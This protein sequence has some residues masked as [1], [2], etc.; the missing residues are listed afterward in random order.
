MADEKVQFNFSKTHIKIFK[1]FRYEISPKGVFFYKKHIPQLRQK[2]N[3]SHGMTNSFGAFYR[4]ISIVIKTQL[5]NKNGRILNLEVTIDDTEY[6]LAN[7][8][9]E[10]TEQDQLETIQNLFI[11]LENFGN[12]YNKSVINARDFN[13]LFSKILRYKGRKP[14]P[15]KAINK[16]YNRATGSF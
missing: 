12:F 5:N 6:L 16:S 3:F 14:V 7:N 11:L 10:N 1:Y 2:N 9:N 15:K 4:N 13:L 8:Y